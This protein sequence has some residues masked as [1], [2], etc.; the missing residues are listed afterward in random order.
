MNKQVLE[1]LNRKCL[2]ACVR[3][4]TPNSHK[5]CVGT[6]TERNG[7]EECKEAKQVS[8]HSYYESTGVQS[9]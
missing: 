1:R 2:C 6:N 8:I 7:E 3:D 4:D 5:Y 9:F